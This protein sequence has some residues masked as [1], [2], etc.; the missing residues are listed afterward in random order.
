MLT[1]L[2]DR[3]NKELTVIGMH[4]AGA[5]PGKVDQL[6]RE[7]KLTY[8]ICEDVP[9]DLVAD[10]KANAWGLTFTAY[11]V[12]A[13]PHAILVGPDGIVID[14][15]TLNDVYHTAIVRMQKDAAKSK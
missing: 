12:G 5:R 15:G 8:P 3:A 1:N 10:P 6:I 11:G 14:R 2:H 9:P 4:V 7:Y 13:I